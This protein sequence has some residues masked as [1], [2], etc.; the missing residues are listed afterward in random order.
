M[1]NYRVHTNIHACTRVHTACSSQRPHS[2]YTVY[3]ILWSFSIFLETVAAIPQLIVVHKCARDMGGFV[4][5]LNSHYVFSLGGY[6]VF[7]LFNWIYKSVWL[8]KPIWTY[9]WIAG[10]LQTSIYCDFFWYYLK[11]NLEGSKMMLPI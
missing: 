2:Y 9:L 11:A 4:D 10:L 3:E 6:R 1:W 8:R 5:T 7:Y